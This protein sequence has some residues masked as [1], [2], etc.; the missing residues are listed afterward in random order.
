MTLNKRKKRA[1]D[2]RAVQIGEMRCNDRQ[3]HG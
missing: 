3:E 1:L 2:E